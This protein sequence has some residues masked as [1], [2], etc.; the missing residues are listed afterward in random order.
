MDGKRGVSDLKKK[1]NICIQS[2][3]L[4]LNLMFNYLF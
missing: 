3:T 2:L 4:L 1:L